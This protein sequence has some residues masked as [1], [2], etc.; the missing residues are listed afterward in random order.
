MQQQTTALHA[1]A[2]LGF[3]VSDS[4][5]DTQQPVTKWMPQQWWLA[6]DSGMMRL[7]VYSMHGLVGVIFKFFGNPREIIIKK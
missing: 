4:L 7:D 5:C 2:F 6:R 3:S 1:G